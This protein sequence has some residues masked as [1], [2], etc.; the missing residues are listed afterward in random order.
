MTTRGHDEQ[1]PLLWHSGLEYMFYE[2]IPSLRTEL[3]RIY[4]VALGRHSAIPCLPYLHGCI[5]PRTFSNYSTEYHERTAMQIK[6]K[7][8]GERIIEHYN[9]LTCQ[10]QTRR[11]R[12]PWVILGVIT[13]R[14]DGVGRPDII[15]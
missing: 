13:L 3:F 5:H 1:S 10:I 7:E 9:L 8:K 12:I 11:E 2:T 6:Q 15:Y 14:S 4:Y